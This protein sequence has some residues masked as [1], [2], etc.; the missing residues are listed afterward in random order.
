MSQLPE[1]YGVEID[2]DLFLQAFSLLKADERVQANPWPLAP[3]KDVRRPFDERHKAAQD[4]LLIKQYNR[5]MQCIPMLKRNKYAD[6]DVM[7]RAFGSR[8]NGTHM[9]L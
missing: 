7:E 9:Q 2:A 8:Q 4:G 1:Y 3:N 5:L 6:W